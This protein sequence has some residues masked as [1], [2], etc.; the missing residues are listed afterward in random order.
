MY[1]LLVEKKM[2]GFSVVEL[3]DAS[4]SISGSITDLDEARKRIY[5]QLL[6]FEKNNWL[7]SE[8]S[9]LKRR[10]YQTELFKNMQLQPGQES[11]VTKAASISDYSVLS[12]ECNEYKGEL[13]IM[14]GEIDEYQS[15]RSRF[16]EL[17]TTLDPL[18]KQAKTRSARLLGKV[19]VLT[20]VLKI[21]SKG[22]F[23]A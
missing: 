3:R 10:Y 9:G 14:L 15:L 12:L 16:P 18:L 7:T 1:T 6:R 19:N 2:D 11:A 4:I 5:R 8:G 20:N 17:E 22:G 13:E 23:V 21:L